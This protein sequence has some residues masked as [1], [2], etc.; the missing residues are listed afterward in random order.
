[1]ASKNPSAQSKISLA[2]IHASVVPAGATLVT[3]RKGEGGCKTA[4]GRIVDYGGCEENVVKKN[5][6]WPD[7]CVD[8]Q[9]SLPEAPDVS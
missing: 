7:A 9:C 6:A 3:R 2:T 1:M 4:A 5:V 8:C